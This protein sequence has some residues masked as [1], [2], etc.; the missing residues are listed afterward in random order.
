MA[1]LIKADGTISEVVPHNQKTFSL[2]ELQGFVHG[3]IELVH[4]PSDRKAVMVVNE[5]GLV[6]D[7]PLNHAASQLADQRI[8]GDALVCLRKEI[9]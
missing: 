6:Y 4:V 1:A 7:L 9:Q 2:E 3:Y 8:V 5:E